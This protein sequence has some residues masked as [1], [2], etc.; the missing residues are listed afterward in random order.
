M[1]KELYLAGAMGCYFNTDQHEY[2]KKWREEAKEYVKEYYD[3]IIITSPTD[4]YEIGKNYHKSESEPMRFDLR[5]VREA[6]VILC[7][8]K[9][10]D[11]SIGTSDEI[12]YAFIKGKP[13]I[14]FLEEGNVKNIHP[15]KLEQIDR[16]ET[17][18]NAMKDALDYIYKYYVDRTY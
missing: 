7:N 8:L 15:W 18:E 4:F 2:P 14:G 17:G 9:D 10:L 11:K 16:I 13:I 1:S 12:F 3:N 5:M 6:D